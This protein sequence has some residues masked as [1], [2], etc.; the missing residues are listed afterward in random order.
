MLTATRAAS[1]AVFSVASKPVDNGSRVADEIR[2]MGIEA[3]RAAIKER[4][5]LSSAERQAKQM[6][7]AM[8]LAEATAARYAAR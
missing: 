6:Q 7:A 2:A 3:V 8:K 5:A 1:P 4:R